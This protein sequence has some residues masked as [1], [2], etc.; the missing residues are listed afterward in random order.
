M[1]HVARGYDTDTAKRFHAAEVKALCHGKKIKNPVTYN[2]KR[3]DLFPIPG[4]QSTA[5]TEWTDYYSLY[6][7]RT[8]EQA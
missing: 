5:G 7:D 1:F 8:W 2:W 3:N 4:G 6:L